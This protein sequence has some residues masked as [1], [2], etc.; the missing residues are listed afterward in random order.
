M[1]TKSSARNTRIDL[2][3]TAQVKRLIEQAA[4]LSGQSVT[5]FVL[6]ATQTS[7]RNV[8]RDSEVIRMSARDRQH[9]LASLDRDDLKPNAALR[10]AAARHRAATQ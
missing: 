9:F 1:A 3:V 10:R 8:I 5:A 4:A 2:R 7:A 6:S